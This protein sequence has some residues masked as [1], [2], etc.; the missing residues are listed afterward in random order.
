M[1]TTGQPV[2]VG[3]IDQGTSSTRFIVFDGNGTI[4]AIHQRE[5][6]QIMKHPGWCEHDP[7]VILETVETCVQEVTKDMTERGLDVSA[8]KGVGVTNQRETTVVWDAETGRPVSNAVVWLDART[9]ATVEQLIEKTPTKKADYLQEKC[10]LPITTYF[11]AVKLRWLL[12]NEIE[13]RKAR[14]D[15]RLMF[16]TID[17]W[18]IYRLTGGSNGGI[19]VTDV[20]NAS[21]TMLMNLRSLKW[22]PELISFFNVENVRLPEIRSSSEVYG[23][24]KS[25]P[26]ADTPIS[27]CVGDQQ[28]ALVGQRCVQPGEV[29][30]TYGTGCFMLFNTG[31]T[32]IISQSGLLT[33]V[34]YQLG[35]DQPVAYALEGSIAIAGAAVKWLRDG[36]GIIKDAKEV[37]E[38]A[39]EVKDTGGVY[40]VPAFSGLY[41]PYWRNDARGCIVGLTQYA[42]R[43]HI[44]RATLEAV[45]WQSKEIMDVMNKEAA[46]PLKKLKVDGGLTNSDLCM[47]LQAD[48]VGIPVERPAM[49]ETTALGAAIAAGLGVGVWPSI[50]DFK[51]ANSHTDFLPTIELEERE[52]R[53]AQWKKAVERSL[54][55]A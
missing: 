32:P 2:Y 50:A 41:A 28:A 53:F 5:F 36:M 47:Q 45:C 46:T 4:V 21:R 9:K 42:T 43:Q 38:L 26:L 10:G 35:K 31:D 14:D 6:P 39:S 24:F 49:R 37:G 34:A 13:V 8:I 16:G 54:G 3:S 7:M 15:G 19:H 22:D 12:E 52:D 11:S 1:A 25:G 29:K 33:T 23:H 18:L 27:G 17:S 30:N 48:I 40:F 44:C 20:T 51:P 55:W